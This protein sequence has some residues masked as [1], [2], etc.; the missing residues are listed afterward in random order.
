[1]KK[2]LVIQNKRI[3]DV[4]IA[5]VLANNLKTI[6]SDSHI[7]YFVYD[8]TQGVLEQNPN[9]DRVILAQDKELKKLSVLWKTIHQIRKE[10]YDIILD[11]YGKLQSR[12]MC[13]LSKAPQRVGFKRAHKKLK[14][15]YYTQTVEF[16]PEAT[17]ACGKALEDRMH[18]LTSAFNIEDPNPKYQI[19]LTEEEKQYSKITTLKKP[20]IML[21]VLGSTPNKSLPYEYTAEIIDHIASTY[22]ATLLFN[23]APHQK[24]EARKIYELC[25]HREQINLDVYE[26]SIRGFITLMNQCDLLVSNEGG[27]VHIAKA[28]DRPTF[29]IYSPYIDKSHWNSFEDGIVHDSVHLL[30]EKPNLFDSFT[31]EERRAIEKT[32]DQLYRELTPDLI[33]KK[34]KP[35]LEQHFKKQADESHR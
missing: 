34:L 17:Q 22:E 18:M 24:E 6:F 8:Y 31:L 9:I 19:F 25:K 29:T 23:Y 4:L 2:I 13:L 26:N 10:R 20:V 14:L 33:L 12:L 15:P 30:E 21:G 1:M 35:F 16:L 7:S 3:G 32:P 27:S 28:L 5:S 11:P